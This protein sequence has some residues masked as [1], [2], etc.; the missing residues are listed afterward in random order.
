MKAK[1][2]ALIT[3]LRDLIPLNRLVKVVTTVVGLND[4]DTTIKTTVWED[5]QGCVILAN[6]EPPRMTPRSKHYA[7]KY[8]WFRTQLKS[9]N[10]SIA[11]I[12]SAN[13]N[14][15]FLTKGLRHILFSTNRFRVM[16]W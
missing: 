16:G 1:Y 12:D 15:N 10:I 5:N 3:A 6:L 7:I 9:N 14:T 2:I 4:S 8:H 13:Q 11:P